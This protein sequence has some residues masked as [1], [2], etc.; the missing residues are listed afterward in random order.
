[1]NNMLMEIMN[2]IKKNN[3]E[4]D[5]WKLLNNCIELKLNELSKNNAEQSSALRAIMKI[6]NGKNEAI[7]ALCE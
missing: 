7:D 3:L 4:V 6:N 2:S 5:V 1:M